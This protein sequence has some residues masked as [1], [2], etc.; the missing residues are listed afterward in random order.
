MKLFLAS[1]FDEVAQLLPKK[2]GSVEGKKVLF[3]ANASDNHTGDKWWIKTDRDAFEKL[4]CKMEDLDLRAVSSEELASQLQQADIIHFCGGSTLYLISL[5]KNRGLAQVITDFVGQDK[6]IYTGTSAG[7][8]VPAKGLDLSIYDAEEK[9]YLEEAKGGDDHYAGLD[10]VN[11]LI[12]PHASNRDFL[13]AN[14]ET[15]KHLPEN[16]TPLLFLN[17]NHAVW[18]E[19][20]KFEILE[21]K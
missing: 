7:S 11:F 6:I 15:A 21:A 2:L 19:D 1:S 14:I 18:V 12:I 13:E 3:V 8:M 16:T 20:E 5:I 17:D 4:G 10:L 9:P